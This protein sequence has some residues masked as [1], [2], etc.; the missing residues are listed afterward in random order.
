MHSVLSVIP[1]EWK[2][3][4]I[5]AAYWPLELKHDVTALSKLCIN[6]ADALLPKALCVQH[7]STTAGWLSSI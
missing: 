6:E 4:Y 7:R 5:L 3:S 2:Q 1:G